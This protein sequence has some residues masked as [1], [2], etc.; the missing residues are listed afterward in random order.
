M[1][2][3]I[4][5]LLAHLSDI[6]RRLIIF[7]ARSHAFERAAAR[8][9]LVPI[10]Y[11]A[12]RARLAYTSRLGELERRLRVVATEAERW[13]VRLDTVFDSL[14][15]LPLYQKAGIVP[16][17][18]IR[19]L[20]MRNQFYLVRVAGRFATAGNMR[21]A[22][23][24]YVLRFGGSGLTARQPAVH[25]FFPKI[26]ARRYGGADV[27]VGLRSTLQFWVAVTPGGALIGSADKIPANVRAGFVYGP[28]KYQF[29]KTHV[30]GAGAGRPSVEWYYPGEAV[31]GGAKFRNLLVLR[32]P[33]G[34]SSCRVTAAVEAD[35]TLPAS[36]QPLLGKRRLLR[37]TRHFELRMAGAGRN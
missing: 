31:A 16:P 36:L 5:T 26:G 21:I 10:G 19:N 27:L 24:R 13:Q 23:L 34:S 8:K 15:V 3:K 18:A 12:Q 11:G 20:S 17:V 28:V 35:V 30:V 6:D 29:G 4:T 37:D 14:P 7:A 2:S 32:L 22:S 9:G 33:E 1:K 25:A